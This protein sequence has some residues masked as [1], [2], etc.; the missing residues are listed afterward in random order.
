MEIPRRLAASFT[1]G[2]CSRL[3]RASSAA[4]VSSAFS[5]AA[6]CHTSYVSTRSNVKSVFRREVSTSSKIP[7]APNVA[8]PEKP[9]DAVPPEGAGSSIVQVSSLN[10]DAFVLKSD[11]PVILDCYAD[12]CA[13]CRELTPKLVKAVQA[14][15]GAVRMGMLNVDVNM[16]LA[17]ALEIKELPTVFALYNGR[18]V[19]RMQGLLTD[20][21]IKEVMDTLLK[22]GGAQA[23]TDVIAEA[24]ALLKDKNIPAAVKLFSQLL[25]DESLKA[26]PE[27]LSGLL[28]CALAEGNLDAA[29]MLVDTIK[30]E[31]KGQLDNKEVKKAL[32]A[33]DL[34]IAGAPARGEAAKQEAELVRKIESDPSDMQA[35]YDLA[36]LQNSAGKL[37]AAMDQCFEMIK[38]DKMWKDQAA[39]EFLLKM[40]ASLGPKD[41]LVKKNTRRLSNLWFL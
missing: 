22:I 36:V 27:A 33:F 26:K 3:L 14:T 28:R 25:A 15:K 35:R 34:A 40:F 23:T 7:P 21:Q 32:A 12:W 17:Q 18:P 31:C 30:A 11:V 24:D 8:A 10:F 29:R 2:V 39:R 9:K 4:F 19:G 41:E 1:S 16:E 38:R 13:P 37:Q 5:A 20:D 6:A